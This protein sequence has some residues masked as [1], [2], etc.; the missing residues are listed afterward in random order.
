MGIE[1]SSFRPALT[2]R[3][4]FKRSYSGPKRNWTIFH[5]GSVSISHAR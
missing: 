4:T 5:N 2:K 1:A 3:S